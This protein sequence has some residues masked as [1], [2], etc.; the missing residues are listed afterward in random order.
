MFEIVLFIKLFIRNFGVSLHQNKTIRH[1]SQT[2][3]QD[4][5]KALGLNEQIFLSVIAAYNNIAPKSLVDLINATTIKGCKFV[6]IKGYTSDKSENTEIADMLMNIGI[7]YGNMVNKDETTLNTY[8][9]DTIKDVLKEAVKGHNYGK[10][11]LSKFTD[12]VNPSAEVLE[13]LPAALIAMKQD[14]DKAPR[15]D[16]NIKLTPVLWFNTNTK[17]LLLFGQVITKTAIV[18]GDFKKVASAPLTV[19]KNI[20]RDTLKKSDLRTL[21]LP[22]ILGNVKLNGET[23][24]LS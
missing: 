14:S 24:E 2:T 10:Y 12:K 16:N 7:S 3:I 17:N 1:M 11:D 8:D 9:I 19:A 20:I 18:K 23:L 4:Q 6:N 22:N 13:L 15:T 5:L 21:S